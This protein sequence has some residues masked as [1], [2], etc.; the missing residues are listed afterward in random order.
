MLGLE[1]RALLNHEN[2]KAKHQNTMCDPNPRPY[3]E[4]SPRI[5]GFEIKYLNRSNYRP[6][7]L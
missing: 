4:Y 5:V 2:C 6:K 1:I 3:I 7:M